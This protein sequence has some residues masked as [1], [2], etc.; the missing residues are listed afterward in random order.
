MKK[1]TFLFD[2]RDG[3]SK[4]Y[5]VKWIPEEAPKAILQI[6]HGMA[7]Y[8][9]RYEK[10]AEYMAQN[11]FLVVGDDHLGHGNTAKENNAQLGYI[12]KDHS[13]TVMV[14]DEHRLKKLIQ[15]EYPGISYFVLGHSMG[16]FII[17]N[18]IYRYGTGINGAIIM[19]TGMQPKAL[20]A[21]SKGLAA[22][23]E[24]IFGGNHVAK[25][26]NS[27]AFGTYNNKIDNPETVSAWLTRDKAI[28][29]A[30][31]AD[32]YCGFTFTVNGFKTLFN[33]IWNLH[34]KKNLEQIPKKLPL[35]VTS[36]ES[37]P[38][39]EYGKAVKAV[40]ESYQS[41]NIED[42]TLKLY[43]EHRHEILNEIGK[44]NVYSDIKEWIEA[45]L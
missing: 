6:T 3:K 27:L 25:M 24:L 37:D 42:V 33:L 23:Q 40:Y 11:G 39:G 44:E 31:N 29:D 17:R 2:S 5:A 34:D 15:E 18:Y 20:L 36:G 13:D 4:I 19:G 1:E 41:L 26:I 45:H 14:R 38:V 30:Y 35:L 10:F 12:C 43:P 8:I 16:S 9:E 7:E 22:I 32:H 28:Q 21:F